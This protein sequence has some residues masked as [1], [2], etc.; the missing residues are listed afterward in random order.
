LRVTVP[1][2]HLGAAFSL[3]E[4][5][6]VER[7][8]EEYGPDGSLTLVLLVPDADGSTLATQIRNATAGAV[9]PEICD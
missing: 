2:K 6:R 9:M 3:F 7:E 8:S 4:K 1:V 5:A